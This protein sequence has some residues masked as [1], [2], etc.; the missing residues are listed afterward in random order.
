MKLLILSLLSMVSISSWAQELIHNESTITVQ[1]GAVLYV[2][3]TLLNT[4]TGVIANSGTIELKGDF[5]NGNPAGWNSPNPNTLK[6]SGGVNSTVTSNTANFYDVVVQKDAGFTV[7]LADN[8]NVTHNLDF[9]SLTSGRLVTGNFDVKLTSAATVTG[10]D[11]DE[12]VATTGTG[13]L[14]KA[15][16]GGTT[17]L[18]PVGDLTNY[19]PLSSTFTSSTAGSLRTRVNAVVHPNKPAAATDFISRYWDVDQTGLTGYTNTM[20]GTYVAGDV[21]GTSTLVKGAVYDGSNWSYAGATNAG[22]TVIG[23]TTTANADFTGTNF[24]GKAILKVFLSGAL[25]G[26]GIPPMSTTLNSVLPIASPYSAAPWNAPAINAP[27]IPATA[28]DWIL[29][30]SR[31]PSINIISQTSAFVL[32][33]GTIVNPDGSALT[34]KNAIPNA[35]VS[36]RHRNHLGIRTNVAIDLVNPT[37]IDFSTVAGQAMAYT[38]TSIPPIPTNPNMRLIGSSYALWGGNASVTGGAG[39]NAI[40]RVNYGGPGNDNAA[41]VAALG[42]NI[43]SVV[44][45]PPSVIV[46]NQSDLNLN[47]KVSYGGPQNDNAIIVANLLGNIGNTTLQHLQ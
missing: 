7:N 35:I 46:Y 24:F 4:A 26:T 17:F 16:T 31:D 28:T 2:E 8:M 6:F 15:V 22:S 29:V 38:N 36:I 40:S 3:G 19:T 42:G 45:N 33:D 20:T 11:A 39:G 10:V 41:L 14:Q 5:T 18:F 12:Y 1:A 27:S 25:P 23:S 34:L 37:S 43:G 32:N 47:G 21:T 30:E 44:G 13:G 9:N